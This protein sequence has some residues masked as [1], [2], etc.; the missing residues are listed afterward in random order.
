MCADCEKFCASCDNG[1][2]MQNQGHVTFN[3]TND[4]ITSMNYRRTDR[5]KMTQMD[6]GCNASKAQGG[7]VVE[8]KPRK[9]F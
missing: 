4:S 7:Q 8:S 1:H 5:P 9:Y 3:S 2:K 6:C